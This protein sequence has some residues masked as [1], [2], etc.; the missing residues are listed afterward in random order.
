MFTY[1]QL[2]I[3]RMTSKEAAEIFPDAY[4]DMVYIDAIHTF[5]HV[6]ADIGYWLP[7][8]RKGGI[9][10]GHDYGDEVWV[11]VKDAVHKWFGDDIE[12]WKENGVWIKRL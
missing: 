1:P 7:K 12:I 3:L 9:I 6:Y 2:R 11:E 8:V 10:A 5:E 4:L